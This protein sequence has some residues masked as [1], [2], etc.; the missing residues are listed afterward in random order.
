M[1]EFDEI[2]SH[3]ATGVDAKIL[4]YEENAIDISD[5]TIDIIEL[6]GGKQN[7]ILIN[8]EKDVHRYQSSIKQL[9]KVSIQNFVHL[10]GTNGRNKNKESLEKDLTYILNF[11]SKFNPKIEPKQIKINEFSEINDPGVQIQDGPLGCYCSHLRALIYGYL[12]YEDYTIICEDDI[13]ITNTEKIEKYIKQIPDDWD[14]ICLN[15]RAKNISYGDL[16]FY[17]FTDDFHSGH[18]YI[19]RNKCLPTLFSGMYP[20]IDQVDVL[21]ANMVTELN[22]YNI[23]DTVYQ[24][25]LETNTQ[26][27]LNIIFSSPNYNVVTDALNKSEE[28]LNHFANIILP[29]NKERNKLIVKHL[30]YD[31]IYNFM[32]TKSNN[33]PGSN[34]EDYIF[35]NP[36]EGKWRHKML[37]RFVAFFL[38]CS[39]KGID[40]KLASQSLVNVCLFTL[41]KFT[42]LHDNDTKAYGFGSTAHTYRVG[43]DLLLKRYNQKLRWST[44]GH[45]DPKTIMSKELEILNKLKNVNSVPKLIDSVD[46]DIIMEYRGESIYNDF[47]LPDD[48]KQQITNIFSELTDNGIFYPEFRLQNILVLDGKI[49]F[50]DFGLAEF[51]DNCDNTENVE[52]FIK[53]LSLLDDKFKVVTEL[54]ARH[55]LIST[56]LEN[57]L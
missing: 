26:N 5:D 47:N 10:K 30:M 14:V 52:K 19:V 11:I 25:N 3:I 13:S 35:D 17:K 9:K 1:I 36:Y 24:K 34:I 43:D 55:I 7:C 37:V 22:I 20:I 8:M 44:E 45:D 57:V 29:D 54:N 31:V 48:W 16:P 53:Y 39:K 50:V 4:Q 40:P 6:L 27:N 15:S 38:Q 12:N 18:F 56:F 46:M 32:L 42:E 49:S 28:I 41:N 23:P 33:N 2:K 21:M 51:R